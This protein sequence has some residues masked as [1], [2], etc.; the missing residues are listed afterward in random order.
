MDVLAACIRPT[1]G[2]RFARVEGDRP[3]K[4]AAR[5][6]V[7]GDMLRTF[8]TTEVIRVLTF[9]GLRWEFEKQLLRARGVD[10]ERDDVIS[11]LRQGAMRTALLALERE[12][13]VY[14]ASLPR[15][16]GRN[17]FTVR[18][19]PPPE[20]AVASVHTKLVAQYACAD[21]A[22]CAENPTVDVDAAWLDFSGPLSLRA[23]GALRALW[24]RG[25]LRFVAVTCMRGRHSA[26]VSRYLE[27]HKG[28]AEFLASALRGGTVDRVTEYADG[29]P[30]VQVHIS[31]H[32][33][34]LRQQSNA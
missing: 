4:G 23:V 3:E 24:R 7:I 15:M 21:F 13:A 29:T 22:K 26:E 19:D 28:H 9:P 17:L 30:M 31:R 20:W 6:S 2:V 16:P 5:G 33:D 8:G 34:P 11:R 1:S 27:Q 12:P 10:S 14:A 32:I 25:R 18:Q